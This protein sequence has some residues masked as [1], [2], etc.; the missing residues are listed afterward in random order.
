MPSFIEIPPLGNEICR[1]AKY[2]LTD[3]QRTGW[4]AERF[5]VI[6]DCCLNFGHFAFY[7]PLEGLGSTYT[8]HLRIIGKRV[9]EF[10]LVLIELFC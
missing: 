9:V 1:H 7:T 6:A 3:G 5:E 2:V 4:T 8:I 10:L